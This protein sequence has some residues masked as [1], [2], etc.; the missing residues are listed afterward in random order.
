MKCTPLLE[1]FQALASLEPNRFRLNDWAL[2][3]LVEHDLFEKP[4]ATFPDH[5]LPRKLAR[6]YGGGGDSFLQKRGKSVFAHQHVECGGRGAARRCD[7]F[8][9]GRGIE[10]RAV[11]QFPRAGNG[12]ARE[13][14]GKRPRQA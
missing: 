6:A 8:P 5:A 1:R 7:V 11:E 14:F 4:A 3:F 10:R 13:L 2:V 12:L 9:Q